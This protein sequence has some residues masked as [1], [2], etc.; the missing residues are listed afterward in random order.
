MDDNN[1]EFDKII[2][3]DIEEQMR[4]CYIDYA[5][6]VI[7]ARALPD[8]RDGLKPV[9]RRILYAMRELNLEPSK[10]FRKSAR[11]VGDTMGK[12]HPHGDASIYDAMVRLA[13]EF[14]TRYMLVDGHG[15]F[16]SIDGDDAAAQRYT[17]ARL[18]KMSMEMLLDIDKETVDFSP[19]YD[20]T[21][22]EP[23]VLPAR[24]PN[25]LINGSSG[26]AV[27]MATNIP[28]HNIGEVIDGVV[29]IIDNKVNEGTDTDIEE[30]IE[31]ITGPDFPTGATILGTQG[32]KQAYRTG[33]G[34]IRIRSEA[35]I[36]TTS[37]GRQQII[38]TEIPFQVNKA[39][40][41]EKI[42]ELVK[43]KRIE[44]ISDLRDESDRNGIRIVI[45]IKRDANADVI[46]NQL[47][48]YSSLQESFGVIMIA[49]VNDE[50]KVLNLKEMLTLYL[51]HQREVV[52][53][54]TTFDLNKARKRVHILEGLLKALDYIDEVIALIRSSKDTNMAKARL[55]E[56]FELSEEQ[57]TAIVEMRLRALTGLERERLEDEFN[58]L[59]IKIKGFEEILG[60]ENKLYGVIREEILEVRRKYADPRR[61]K[62][63][64]DEGDIDMEELIE[65]E[66]SV[67]TMTCSDYIKRLP[68]TTYRSQN[69]GGKGIIGMQTS[70][71]DVAKD[72]FI[73][74]THDYLHFFTS[75]GRLYRLKAYEIPESS[76]TA[77]G[78]NIVNLLNLNPGE[79]ISSVISAR[80]L[81]EA[82]DYLLMATKN[83][84]IKKTP[85]SQFANIRKGGLA[86]I[87]IREDDELISANITNGQNEILVATG[88]GMG[89]K[90]LEEDIRATSRISM[91]VNAIRLKG[92]DVVVGAEVLSKGQ[93]V[94]FVSENGYGK[95]TTEDDFRLQGRNGYGSRVY[96]TTDKTGRLV[97]I[98]TINDNEETMIITSEG[99]IIRLRV[100]DI[101]TLGRVTQGVRLINLD[102]GVRVVSVAK[103]SEEDVLAAA[104][105]EENLQADED[106]PVVE[107]E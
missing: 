73:C 46:L 78:R 67:I 25:L 20:E 29:K 87:N 34:K 21:Y 32:I 101:S 92:D 27:G 91:G 51:E 62:I 36:E 88:T 43:E 45:E 107:T 63:V 82:G 74:S 90:F 12:Y 53:R 95:S 86:A 7:V 76:R 48:K 61:T 26:I 16:G 6:S 31:I 2:T 85:L 23:V 18:S 56:R 77:R 1:Q 79:K 8:V 35:V 71:E 4:K 104:E 24:V 72:V 105:A 10:P 14:S 44:G 3:I 58:Q 83:G 55:M 93:K 94:L 5:M 106:A 69:R 75:L 100:N 15:N 98:K 103:I 13:Q 59:M 19:N 84:V 9:H 33:R 30:L 39:R 49:L 65:E 96:R 70:Q 57:A 42:A 89:I 50:P 22:K 64:Y 47:Y 80:D 68:L 60:D 97:A 99:V 37:T 11:I 54:R 17:E 38:V 81:S 52:T 28:P 102:S 66:T 40:L 41:S